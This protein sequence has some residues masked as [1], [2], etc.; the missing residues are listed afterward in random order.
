M[1]NKLSIF[2]SSGAYSGLSPIA[3]GTFGSIA[4]FALWAIAKSLGLIHYGLLGPL[5]L[6]ILT[7]ISIKS[8]SEVIADEDHP[9]PDPQWIVI[10]EWVGLY[11]AILIATP[12]TWLEGLAALILF[13]IFDI[14]KPYPVSAAEKLPGALGIILDDLVAGL[15]AGS[16]L[17]VLKLVI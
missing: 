7:T 13:R 17:I 6:I 4:A 15:F 11:L 5:L 16:S 3:P 8:V 9:N 14:I 2:I 12:I 10:D 1:K